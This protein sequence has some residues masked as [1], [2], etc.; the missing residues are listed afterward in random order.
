MKKNLIDLKKILFSEIKSHPFVYTLLFVIL[1]LAFWVRVYRVSDLLQFY[2]D[3]G[4]DALVIWDLWHKGKPFLIGPITGLKGI[5]LGPFY[6]YLIAPF[7]LIGGGNPS[8]PTVFLSFTSVLALFFLYILGVRMHS[9]ITGLI[10]AFIGAF[11]YNIFTLSRWLSNPTPM[12]LISVLFFW[13]LWEITNQSKS[14]FKYK[15]NNFLWIMSAL[16]IGVALHFESASAVFY[17][18]LFVIFAVWQR[19]KIPNIKYLVIMLLMFFVTL[20]PQLI[21]N[22]RHENI[23]LNNFMELLFGEKAFKPITEFILIERFKYFWGVYSGKIF[24]GR[25][26]EAIII[27]TVSFAVIL[28]E[29]AKLKKQLALFA[30]FFVT[31]ML[32]YIFFQGNY[33]NIY[34]Y[35]TI[36][37]FLPLIL[38]FSIGLGELLTKW[39]GILIVIWFLY[40]FIGL[41]YTLIR[42][43]LTATVSTRPIAIEDQLKAINWIYDNSRGKGEF[44]IDVYVPPVIPHAYDYLFLWQFTRRCGESLC[45]Y[46]KDINK[47]LLYTLF[48]ADPPNPERLEVW[49]ER[50]KGIGVVKEEIKYGHITVQRRKRI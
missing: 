44:N 3:Q 20:I 37:Y 6:Y 9:R 32:G 11:S 50:Q 45:G 23:L 1:F 30:I 40:H 27:A 18:P 15:T 5:F 19:K 24:A 10:A 34:D 28:S 47:P 33:G 14:K 43:Y 7:Y 36:G 42:N 46:L 21:F 25:Q 49:L 12:L 29:V 35:Y 17:I 48:E 8:Y 22:W 16:L 39:G 26:Q 41:N 38:F 31:P 2:Y 13:C 4:R